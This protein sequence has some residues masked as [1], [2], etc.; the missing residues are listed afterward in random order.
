MV[1]KYIYFLPTSGLPHSLGS[2]GEAFSQGNLQRSH[3]IRC[4][5]VCVYGWMDGCVRVDAEGAFK[6]KHLTRPCVC[7]H[8]YAQ[9]RGGTQKKRFVCSQFSQNG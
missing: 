1:G 9:R 3:Q 8:E 2:F 4:V 7:L 6:S 5:C